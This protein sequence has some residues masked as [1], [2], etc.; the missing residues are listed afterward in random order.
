VRAAAV[1]SHACSGF[2]YAIAA[3][4]SSSLKKSGVYR[5]VLVIGAETSR[6][7]GGGDRNACVLFGDGA[8]TTTMVGRVPGGLWPSW[9]LIWVP[10]APVVIL[11]K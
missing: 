3:T 7:T 10:M 4:N 2:T 11:A 5:N 9:A 6:V 1:R 8:G